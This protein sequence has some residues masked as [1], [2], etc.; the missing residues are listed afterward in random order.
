MI[1]RLT[2]GEKKPIFTVPSSKAEILHLPPVY[3]YEE[4]EVAQAL[5]T[6][7][8]EECEIGPTSLKTYEYEECEVP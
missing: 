6:Y 5:K 2:G 1:Y 4:C 8:Y 7:E 3:I